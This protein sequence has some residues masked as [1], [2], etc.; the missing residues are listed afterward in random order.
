MFY[1]RIVKY[2][3]YFQSGLYFMKSLFKIRMCLGARDVLNKI[4]VCMARTFYCKDSRKNQN[5]QKQGKEL[6]SVNQD[7]AKANP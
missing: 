4:A 5:A 2:T 7:E 6:V 3:L 1:K